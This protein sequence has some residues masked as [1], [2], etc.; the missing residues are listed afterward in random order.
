MRQGMAA[1]DLY[2]LQAYAALIRDAGFLINTVEDLTADWAVILKERLA[3]YRRLRVEAQ[4]ANAP[5]GHDLF[6]KSYVRFVD[7]VNEAILGG[8]RF[9]GEKPR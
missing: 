8:G 7:L 6:Y 3:F 2:S 1:A 4:E 5:A 9:S